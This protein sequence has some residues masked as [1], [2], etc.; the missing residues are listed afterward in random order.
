MRRRRGF[1]LVELLVIVAI[2][3]LLIG[4]LMP[5]LGRAKTSARRTA[6]ATNLRQIGAGLR[7]YLDNN[8]DRFPFASFMPSISPEPLK[9]PKPIHIADVLAKELQG[10]RSVFHC[11][12]DEPDPARGAPNTNLSY[13]QSERSSYEYRSFLGGRLLS[14]VIAELR[15]R[16]EARYPGRIVSENDLW[17]MR[18]YNNFHAPAGEPGARRYLYIDGHVAD[19]QN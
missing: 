8:D 13:F 18:D 4:I 19:Y 17:L 3:G 1:T 5:A 2:I 9:T 14:R 15:E 7:L 12:N 6:C 10:D 16:I 11:P